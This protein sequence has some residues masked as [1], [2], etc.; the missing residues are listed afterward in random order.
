MKIGNF[1][2]C[3]VLAICFGFMGVFAGDNFI[4]YG[5]VLMGLCSLPFLFLLFENNHIQMG[6]LK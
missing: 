6:E 2:G 5:S 3:I 4:N 1:L